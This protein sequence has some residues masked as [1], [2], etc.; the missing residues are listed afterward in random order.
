MLISN[1]KCHGGGY[2]HIIQAPAVINRVPLLQPASF[3]QVLSWSHVRLRFLQTE[4]EPTLYYSYETKIRARTREVD[5]SS[6][7]SISL[8]SFR[9]GPKSKPRGRLQLVKSCDLDA[10]FLQLS[11]MQN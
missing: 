9:F 4:E 1:W 7:S 8:Q 3:P 11:L 6:A 10:Y 2:L 5:S